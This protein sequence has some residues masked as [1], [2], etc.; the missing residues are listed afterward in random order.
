[1]T[2]LFS[3]HAISGTTASDLS[4]TVTA[5]ALLRIPAGKRD[6]A[7][8]SHQGQ[9]EAFVAVASFTRIAIGRFLE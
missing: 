5:K 8:S 2:K 1:M 6:A 9:A 3:C 7:L 4:R